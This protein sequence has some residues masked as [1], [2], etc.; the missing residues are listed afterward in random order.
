MPSLRLIQTDMEQL[1]TKYDL[2]RS[3]EERER[4]MRE[5]IEAYDSNRLL[6]TSVDDLAAYFE[7]TYR[8]EPLRLRE[9]D[10]VV[11][12][13]EARVDVS[14]RWEYAVHDRSRPAYVSGTEFSMEVPFEG[15]ADLFHMSPS[16]ATLTSPQAKVEQGKIVLEQRTANPDPVV[17]RSEFERDLSLIRSYVGWVEKDVI[18]F[19]DS[20]QDQAGRWIEA[21]RERLLRDRGVAAQLGYPLRRRNDAP[22]TYAAPEIRRKVRPH[23][24]AASSAAF[25]PEPALADAEYEHILSVIRGMAIVL[26]R[27]PR[28][29]RTMGEEELRDHILVQLNAQYEGQATGETFNF[30]GKTDILIRVGERNV[31]VGECKIW[32]GPK[33]LAETVDQ[34]LGYATWR[35]TKMAIVIFN[36]NKDFSSVLA[37][38]PEVMRA[39]PNVKRE[40]SYR[41]ETGFRYVLGHRDDPNRELTLTVLAFEVPV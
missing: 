29:F 2:R 4:R 25:V 16:T 39:H 22:R 28:A 5:E 37:K 38:I 6:N 36:R 8:V 19:N 23:P 21:R 27:S 13:R 9:E 34:I 32:R 17:I 1:F 26:E 15:E 31:F 3:L 35:D 18:R 20:L 40:L 30:E 7:K 10:L 24:P 14:Q 41:S 33:V 12:H 11:D